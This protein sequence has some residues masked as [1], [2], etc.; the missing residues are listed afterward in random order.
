MTTKFSS[1][2]FGSGREQVRGAEELGDEHEIG[3]D[4]VELDDDADEVGEGGSDSSYAPSSTS[5]E[6]D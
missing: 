6:S 4:E 3:Y 2:N 5:S 1:R